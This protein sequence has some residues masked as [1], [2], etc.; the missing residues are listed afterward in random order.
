MSGGLKWHVCTWNGIAVG[1]QRLEQ[2]L[3]LGSRGGAHV[4]HLQRQA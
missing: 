3:G 1:V 4:Q 2:L